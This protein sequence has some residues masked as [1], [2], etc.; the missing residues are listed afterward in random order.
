MSE[1]DKYIPLGIT[2]DEGSQLDVVMSVYPWSFWF[3]DVINVWPPIFSFFL[4]P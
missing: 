3:M 2:I 1:M 4:S